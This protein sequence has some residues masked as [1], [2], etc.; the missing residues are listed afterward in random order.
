MMPKFTEARLWYSIALLF[1]YFLLADLFTDYVISRE[2]DSILQM[3]VSFAFL[4]FTF[5]TIKW[6]VKLWSKDV[7]PLKKKEND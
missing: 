2:L 7:K 6:I 4:V 5:Y 1:I 3:T